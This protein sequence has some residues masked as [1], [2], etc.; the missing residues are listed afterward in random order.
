MGCERAWVDAVWIEPVAQGPQLQG[1]GQSTLRSMM[2]TN[3]GMPHGKTAPSGTLLA[4]IR[5]RSYV[6]HSVVQLRNGSFTR[7]QTH[8]FVYT[9]IRR[10]HGTN[11]GAHRIVESDLT[12][13]ATWGLAL[14]R[15]QVGGTRASGLADAD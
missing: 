13:A 12:L 15:A 6:G 1:L 3:C 5:T 8:S 4:E 10:N 2:V 11:S 14:I 7:H 9:S